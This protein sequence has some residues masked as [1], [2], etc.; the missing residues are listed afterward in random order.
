MAAG[1]SDALHDPRHDAQ[2]VLGAGRFARV[3]EPSPPAVDDGDFFAD[4]PVRAEAPAGT[5]VVSPVPGA[6]VSSTWSEWL[7]DPARAE[8]AAWAAERWLGAYRRLPPA[9]ATLVDTRLALHRLAGYVISPA[10]RRMNTKIGLRFTRGGFGTPFFGAGEQ[11][12]VAGTVLVRQRAGTADAEPVSTLAA[13]AKF[14]LDGP[15]DV[16]WAQGFDVPP[17]GDPDED[18]AVDP[19]AAAFLGDWY[20]FTW[21]VL[22]ELRSDAGATDAGRV[23]LWPEHFDAAF[24]CLPDHRRITF[25]A[26]PGDAAIPEPYLYALPWNL[27]RD[28]P[29]LWN[30]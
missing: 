9:P 2:Q 5:P 24:D 15:P 6:D 12:R 18:L 26:S 14:V 1:T 3:L 20:G 29:D 11:V 30:A 19:V 23:Q 10:R 16:E 25:G 17:L 21:S 13:A 28:D 22:E 4:D 8:Y 7:A 27:D